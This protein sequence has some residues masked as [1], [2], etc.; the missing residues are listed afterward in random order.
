[1]WKDRFWLFLLCKQKACV[2]EEYFIHVAK[3]LLK[4]KNYCRDQDLSA[5]LPLSL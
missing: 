1:M 3:I 2:R 4:I 5:Y